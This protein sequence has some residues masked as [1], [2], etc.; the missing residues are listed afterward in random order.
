M[1]ARQKHDSVTTIATNMVPDKLTIISRHTCCA[2]LLQET[3]MLQMKSWKRWATA[4]KQCSIR[5]RTCTAGTGGTVVILVAKLGLPK[6]LEVAGSKHHRW[7]HHRE[8]AD[9]QC[10]LLMSSFNFWLVG[11]HDERHQSTMQ[12]LTLLN[13][14]LTHLLSSILSQS[15]MPNHVLEQCYLEKRLQD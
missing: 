7:N 2:D 1:W 4:Q 14:R 10:M 9:S 13:R 11:L 5:R 15:T 6:P 3:E 8:F 12:R